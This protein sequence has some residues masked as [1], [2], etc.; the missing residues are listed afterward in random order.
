M[1]EKVHPVKANA[2]YRDKSD[3]TRTK[4]QQHSIR[5]PNKSASSSGVGMFTKDYS[6]A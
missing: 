4:Y 5:E 1:I 6:T 2:T 3:N